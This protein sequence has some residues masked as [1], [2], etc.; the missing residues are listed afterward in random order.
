MHQQFL[1]HPSIITSISK[2]QY[3]STCVPIPNPVGTALGI[4]CKRREDPFVIALP[5]VPMEMQT[6][7]QETVIPYLKSQFIL[8]AIYHKTICTTGIGEEKLAAILSDWEKQLPSY[9]LLAY[10]S[11]IGT[12]KIRLITVLDAIEESKSAIEEEIEK[13]LPL[14]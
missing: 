14:I 12:V 3:V 11:D 5:G 9:I 10:L 1:S 2:N 8:P 7:L 4:G 6:M 13:M